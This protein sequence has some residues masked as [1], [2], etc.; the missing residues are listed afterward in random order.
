VF[1]SDLK[2]LRT[3]ATFGVAGAKRMQVYAFGDCEMRYVLRR[4]LILLH[5][6]AAAVAAAAAPTLMSVV[7]LPAPVA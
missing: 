7:P 3:A 6:A 5:A 2:T 4:F 1:L